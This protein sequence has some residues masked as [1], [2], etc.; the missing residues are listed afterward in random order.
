M[1]SI[2]EPIDKDR[3]SIAINEIFRSIQGE[4]PFMGRYALFIRFAGCNLAGVCKS[5]DTDFTTKQIVSKDY[6]IREIV[7][8]AKDGGRLVVFTGGEP[9]LYRN[10]IDDIVREIKFMYPFNL[11]FQVETNGII[12]MGGDFISLGGVVVVSPKKGFENYAID[13][14][15][16]K[17]YAH[18]KIVLGADKDNPTFWDFES[19]KLF[20]KNL[21]EEY[22][23]NR[24]NIWIMPFGATESELRESRQKCWQISVDKNINYSD[25]LHVLV[26]LRSMRGV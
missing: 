19:G 5:C 10:V 13:N 25:R 8:F 6:I 17:G 24:S 23:H 11:I 20:I 16:G 3:N 7:N 21:I 12:K 26:W 9:S 18:F 14:Y 15:A 4:G 1:I 2:T 22:N